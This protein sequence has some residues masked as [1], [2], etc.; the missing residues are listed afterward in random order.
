MPTYLVQIPSSHCFRRIVP[1]DLRSVI[2][3]RELRYSLGTLR[4]REALRAAKKLAA[5]TSLLFDQI[6]TTEMSTYTPEQ[7][8]GII[9]N[10]IQDSLAEDRSIR[11]QGATG[12]REER[13]EMLQDLHSV[14]RES[15]E[16]TKEELETCDFTKA[17]RLL[18]YTLEDQ[19]VQIDKQSEV[20]R[21]LC[22]DL[23]KANIQ[24]HQISMAEDKHEYQRAEQA[25][26]S[27][28]SQY[29]PYSNEKPTVV[30]DEDE[31]GNELLRNVME[32]YCAENEQDNWQPKTALEYRSKIALFLEFA[33]QDI[34]CKELSFKVTRDFKTALSKLPA[35]RTKKAEYKTKTLKQLLA[36]DCKPMS[37]T[38]A[39]NILSKLSA[40]LEY[41][42]KEGFIKENYA[43]DMVFKTS[44]RVQDARSPYTHDELKALF[45]SEYYADDKHEKPFH[46]WTPI[47]ALF[48]GMRANEIAQLHLDDIH[49]KDGVW[50]FDVNNDTPDKK[51]KTPSAK[52]KVPMH[53]FLS[54]TLQLPAYA[55]QLRIAGEQRL[56]PDIA[57]HK[58]D[59][60]GQRISR[61][62]NGD[63]GK[64][65]FKGFRQK[66][67]IESGDSNRKDF[68][69]FR[70]TSVDHLKQK[71]TKGVV[72]RC[73][74]YVHGHSSGD[75]QT[76]A[77]YGNEFSPQTVFDGATKFISHDVDL[78]LVHLANSKWVINPN[79]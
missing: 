7:L 5:A 56:F 71:I 67:G 4:K 27:L 33:G 70:H 64:G 10:Y 37:K 65:S 49:D 72:D 17:S 73:L 59:G 68:H 77:R 76:F 22:F 43:A 32:R 42:R 53:P 50:V 3:M 11:L 74:E 41:A 58:R 39:N 6:R 40:F 36:M 63:G 78:D 57:H 24:L 30:A 54:E 23:A 21:Q 44:K 62:F 48:T 12:T 28:L 14:Y 75:S 20:Y 46:F 55:E 35:N 51:L 8:K 2:G 19:N 25:T 29:P 15:I 79:K 34:K 61:W 60:Y 66:C 13:A 47:I 9:H 16:G 1:V 38:T 26:Q 31:D 45:H 69:S 52:R 18:D